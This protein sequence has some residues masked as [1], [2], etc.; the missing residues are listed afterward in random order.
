MSRS[1]DTPPPY[2][3]PAPEQAPAW[4]PAPEQAEEGLGPVGGSSFADKAVRLAFIRK[5][6]ASNYRGDRRSYFAPII[7]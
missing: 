5:V 6:G 2:W 7:F 1:Y 3:A 4:A